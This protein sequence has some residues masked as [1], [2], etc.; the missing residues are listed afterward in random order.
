MPRKAKLTAIP[1]EEP[2]AE[3]RAVDGEAISDE[4]TDAERMTDVMNEVSVVEQ[5]TAPD[6]Q[7]AGE[8]E[9]VVATK[10]KAKR[11]PAKRAPVAAAAAAVEVQAEVESPKE[12]VKEEVKEDL[13]EDAKVACP[14]CGKKMSAKTL[15]Y[16]HGA[17]CATK[18]PPRETSVS[19]NDNGLVQHVTD[20]MIEEE[21]QRRINSRRSDRAVRREA[22]VS[23]LVQDAF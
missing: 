23:K 22:M 16:S 15:K 11:A 17:N 20:E 2:V 18:K 8:A 7:D 3:Q 10:P 14:D 1:I 9:P 4:K 5:P 6:L 12:E 21:I 19:D 13:K